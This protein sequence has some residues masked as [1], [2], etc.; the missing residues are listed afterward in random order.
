[1]ITVGTDFAK[2][3]SDSIAGSKIFLR[4]SLIDSI[5]EALFSVMELCAIRENVKGS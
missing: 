2:W 1:M 4:T 3:R 5:T